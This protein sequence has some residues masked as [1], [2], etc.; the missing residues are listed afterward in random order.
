VL[1]VT[2]AQH[3]SGLT[4]AR[5][6]PAGVGVSVEPK[7]LHRT[8]VPLFGGAGRGSG[9]PR[10]RG[11]SAFNLLNSCG[12]RRS[13]RSGWTLCDR[14]ETFTRRQMWA[15]PHR[16]P[17][18]R[19]SQSLTFLYGKANLLIHVAERFRMCL[20]DS[21]GSLGQFPGRAQDAALIAGG[22]WARSFCVQGGYMSVVTQKS[23]MVASAPRALPS[24]V[25]VPDTGTI[26]DPAPP[27]GLADA[28][29]LD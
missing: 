16:L 13:R 23:A 28:A 7:S 22:P 29:A 27:P 20:T 26:A 21:G 6:T 5:K 4:V 1:A 11:A 10:G 14:V 2:A 17:G 18:V 12:L 9:G 19:C 15:V 8:Y 24:L 25:S 3:R